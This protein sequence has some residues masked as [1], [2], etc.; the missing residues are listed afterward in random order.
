[1]AQRLVMV[2][3]TQRC[4]SCNACATACKIE[5]N[6]P[7]DIWYNRVLNRG[8]ASPE[9]PEGIYPNLK[10][11][12]VPFACQH[13]E[14]PECVKVC[15]VGATYKDPETGI[16]HQDTNACIGCRM[17]MAACPYT[18][19]R[20]FN[21]REPQYYL[22]FATGGNNTQHQKHTVE[23]CIFCEHR[24]SEGLAPACISACTARARYF[25]DANDPNSEVSRLL[26]E[27]TWKQLLP[28]KGTEPSV[29]YLY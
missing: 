11:H 18:D 29:Y 10:M 25:G 3:D 21:W 23:K 6:L 2:V 14:N 20:V 9:T 8:G 28:E 7:N 4:I 19:V 13:C 24:V 22:D 16:V 27:R 15:P 12:S 26:R 17:C 5:N 1:M